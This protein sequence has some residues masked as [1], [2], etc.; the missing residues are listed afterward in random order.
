MNF[1]STLQLG[2]IISVVAIITGAAAALAMLRGRMDNVERR[3]KGVED[4]LS[5][6]ST[7]VVRLAET[8]ARL[9]S[10]AQRLDRLEHAVDSH[11]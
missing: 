6:L 7:V 9:D 2:D 10:H 3:L 5:S 1:D 11:H 8:G 4:E